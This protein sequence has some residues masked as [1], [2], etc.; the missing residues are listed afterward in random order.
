LRF[1]IF[2]GRGIRKK[3]RQWGG[4]PA[5]MEYKV[6]NAMAD[7]WS[8][9]Y[10]YESRRKKA[11]WGVRWYAGR[12]ALY[13]MNRRAVTCCRPSIPNSINNGV[14]AS[15]PA[16]FSP[17]EQTTPL[18]SPTVSL[19]STPR[20]PTREDAFVS[21]AECISSLDRNQEGGLV[22]WGGYVYG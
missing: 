2:G 20:L 15:C 8:G 16:S 3:R 10:G 18:F 11:G 17:A 21:L 4:K 5:G 14:P 13:L 1:W 19:F 12:G 7:A 9:W 6:M 22:V